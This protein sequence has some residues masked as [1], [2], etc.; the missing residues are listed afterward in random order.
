[1]HHLS[2]QPF[3]F[4]NLGLEPSDRGG[5]LWIEFGAPHRQGDLEVGHAALQ[6]LPFSPG[7]PHGICLAGIDMPQ[8]FDVL[9]ATDQQL[10][11]LLVDHDTRG[12]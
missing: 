10:V 5:L 11:L 6:L 3:G 2:E 4:V 1:M 9:A 12:Q 8:L 7:G